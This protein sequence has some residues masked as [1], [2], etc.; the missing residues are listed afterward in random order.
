MTTTQRIAAILAAD[1][2]GYPC[3]MGEDRAWTGQLR[4]AS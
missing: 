1:A 4:A 3:L 2:V